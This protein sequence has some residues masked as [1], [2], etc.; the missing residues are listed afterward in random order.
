MIDKYIKLTTS[1]GSDVSKN[2]QGQIQQPQKVSGG[3]EGFK[4]EQGL[5]MKKGGDVNMEY[6][7][8]ERR[9]RS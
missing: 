5:K 9:Q 2:I 4:K 3:V 7:K 6:A 1:S 8:K